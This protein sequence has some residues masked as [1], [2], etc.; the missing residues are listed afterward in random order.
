MDSTSA[1]ARG[2]FPNVFVRFRM[3]GPHFA[4]RLLTFFA[5]YLALYCLNRRYSAPGVKIDKLL[6]SS[7]GEASTVR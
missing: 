1:K 4:E 7:H 6:S 2:G 3:A 5:E